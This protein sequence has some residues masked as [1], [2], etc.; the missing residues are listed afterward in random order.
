MAAGYSGTPLAG[1]LGIRPD[2]LAALVPGSSPAVQRVAALVAGQVDP[3]VRL[4]TDLRARGPYDVIVVFV[5]SEA[6]LRERFERARARLAESGGLWVAWPKQSSALAGRLKE[7]H[8]RAFG[9]AAGLVD[10][11]VCAVDQDWSGL[12]FVVRVADRGR[13]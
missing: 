8:V 12:R 4:R 3:S 6:E 11:K 2:A 5:R 10:N 7:A 9:L 13:S 1:K